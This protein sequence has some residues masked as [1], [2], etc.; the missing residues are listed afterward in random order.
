MISLTLVIAQALKFRFHYSL[1]TQNQVDQVPTQ[2]DPH[3]HTQ[4]TWNYYLVFK[5][6]YILSLKFA[7]TDNMNH[8]K[9]TFHGRC[10]CNGFW[11]FVSIL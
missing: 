4:L 9:L 1:K 3:S 6:Q 2:V 5:T 8:N 7:F 10:F 11:L